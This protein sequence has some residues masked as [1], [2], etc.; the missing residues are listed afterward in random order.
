MHQ[1]PVIRSSLDT[2]KGHQPLRGRWTLKKPR[3]PKG[4]HSTD[5]GYADA[6]SGRMLEK[7]VLSSSLGNPGQCS[8]PLT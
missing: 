6:F 1:I 8:A 3:T 7:L 5:F 2:D 4:I